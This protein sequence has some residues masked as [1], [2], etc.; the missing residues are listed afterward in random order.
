MGGEPSGES[1]RK[2][3]MLGREMGSGIESG[4]FETFGRIFN[5]LWWGKGV[6]ILLEFCWI[7]FW[8]NFE[9]QEHLP[10]F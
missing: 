7:P 3:R 2:Y 9:N 8:L 10:A 4:G 6:G 1:D 5:G